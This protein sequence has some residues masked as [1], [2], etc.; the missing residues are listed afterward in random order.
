MNTLRV[1]STG[2]CL[3]LI[4]V[5]THWMVSVSIGVLFYIESMKRGDQ[6][7]KNLKYLLKRVEEAFRDA[8]EQV[9]EEEKQRR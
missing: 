7:F 1:V 4:A 5:H 8:A 2:C 3:F 9:L 6:I